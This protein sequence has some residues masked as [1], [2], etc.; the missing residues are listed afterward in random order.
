MGY[1]TDFHGAFDINKEVDNRTRDVFVA[2]REMRGAEKYGMPNS[3]CQWKLLDDGHSLGWDG[4]EKFYLYIDWLKFLINRVFAPQGYILNG[5]VS[6]QGEE[7]TDMGVL[8]IV[9]NKLSI[10]QARIEFD[11]ADDPEEMV[12]LNN[13]APVI[14]ELY[15]AIVQKNLLED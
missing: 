6:W 15:D 14:S 7:S 8:R 2:L 12:D 11:F 10:G 5:E 13:Q 1:S 4:G 3:Y 9:N